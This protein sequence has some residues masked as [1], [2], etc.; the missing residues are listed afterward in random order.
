MVV[1]AR[2]IRANYRSDMKFLIYD[3]KFKM[4]EGTV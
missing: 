2:G 3:M 1:L 4:V